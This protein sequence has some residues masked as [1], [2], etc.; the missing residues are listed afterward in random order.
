MAS[1]LSIGSLL[2]VGFVGMVFA[3]N[4]ERQP[5]PDYDSGEY[6]FRTHCASCHGQS[7]RGDGPAA[8]TFQRSL[9]DLTTL[10]LR[11]GGNFPRAEV[12]RVVNG[13]QKTTG[14]APGDMPEWGRVLRSLEGDDRT[15]RRQI[16]AIVRHLESMQQKNDE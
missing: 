15:A 11:A 3:S 14:H 1:R 5:K 9:S 2:F 12:T 8:T 10:T 16:D 7:G 4:Q 13:Q 6:L